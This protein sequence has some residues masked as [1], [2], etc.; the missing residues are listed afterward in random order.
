M[1]PLSTAVGKA[2]LDIPIEMLIKLW[3]YQGK[4][5]STA[6]QVRAI[7]FNSFCGETSSA[8]YFFTKVPIK[9]NSAKRKSQLNPPEMKMK[10][11]KIS[12]PVTMPK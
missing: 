2:N 9:I 6:M 4:Q 3:A 12:K 10:K 5:I 7:R 8:E 1:L 11:G